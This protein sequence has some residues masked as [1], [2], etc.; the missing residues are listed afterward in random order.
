MIRDYFKLNYSS[1]DVLK[2]L[3]TSHEN[4]PCI[5]ENQNLKNQLAILYLPL[6]E[7]LINAK[8]AKILN[9]HCYK[10]VESSNR[11]ILNKSI[12]KNVSNFYKKY[13]ENKFSI[14]K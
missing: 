6:I 9:I 8:E 11:T 3:L 14:I 1:I 7:I 4:D 5:M 10:K 12:G 2:M 13:N